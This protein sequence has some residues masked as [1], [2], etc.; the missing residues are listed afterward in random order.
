MFFQEELRAGT[1]RWEDL[2]QPPLMTEYEGAS[3]EGAVRRCKARKA[4]ARH[5]MTPK[6]VRKSTVIWQAQ[7][8]AREI[9]RLFSTCRN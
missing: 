6:N 8:K 2:P 1:V 9:L 3:D 5:L 7:D 4:T